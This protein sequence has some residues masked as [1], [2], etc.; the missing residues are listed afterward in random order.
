MKKKTADAPVIIRTA[1][2]IKHMNPHIVR[3]LNEAIKHDKVDIPVV[4]QYLHR[5]GVPFVATMENTIGKITKISKSFNGDYVGTIRLISLVKLASNYMGVIDNIAVSMIQGISQVK[6]DGFI[7][8]DKTAK[9]QIMNKE[10]NVQ[11][12][13]DGAVVIPRGPKAGE[14]PFAMSSSTEASELMKEAS[15]LLIDEFNKKMSED[16]QS[17]KSEN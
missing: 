15:K 11:S 12:K 7:I 5:P 10:K 3:A 4:Y 2:Q 6:I 13:Q 1:T 17:D 14:I 9:L 8:Y 16:E